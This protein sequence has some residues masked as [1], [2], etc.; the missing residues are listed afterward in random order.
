MQGINS[1][2]ISLVSFVL[3]WAIGF[4]M[5]GYLDKKGNKTI[6]D[7]RV[8]VLM[9]VTLVWFISVMYEIFNPAYH[10]SPL[11]HGLMG[12]IVGFLFKNHD[13]RSDK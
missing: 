5:R 1:S 8:I 6:F 3:G 2:A 4:F 9:M 13:K 11:V 10:T 12:G 7:Y